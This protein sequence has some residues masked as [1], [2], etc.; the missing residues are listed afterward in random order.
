MAVHRMCFS[1]SLWHVILGLLTLGISDSKH[2][3]AVLQSGAWPLKLLGWARLVML[4]FVIPSRFFEF[5]S[6]YVAMIGTGIFLLA[7]LVLLVDF[8]Y[9]MAKAFIKQLEETDLL[10]WCNLLVGVARTKLLE[11][12]AVA[13]EEASASLSN[14]ELHQGTL[15]DAVDSDMLPASVL[16]DY[17][18]NKANEGNKKQHGVQ[19]NY[20][21]FH[22]ISCMAS[23]YA[24]M[25]LPNWNSITLEDHITIIGRSATVVW[26]RIVTSWLCVLLYLW[27]LVDPVMLPD[28]EWV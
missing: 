20:A 4:S 11:Y 9:N 13:T 14:A 24:V 12:E 2:P 3:W 16:D 15:Q 5:Y 22:V 28:H 10:L 17:S 1:L 21:F 7:Q 18:S 23:M 6:R 25:L 27:T 8:A 26:V 19:Y